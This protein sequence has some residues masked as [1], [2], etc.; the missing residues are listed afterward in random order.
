LCRPG[1]V[2]DRS[3]LLGGPRRPAVELGSFVQGSRPVRPTVQPSLQIVLA[4][5]YADGHECHAGEEDQE[6]LA[7]RD[8]VA[9]DRQAIIVATHKPNPPYASG[10]DQRRPG[11]GGVVSMTVVVPSSWTRWRYTHP[12]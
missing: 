6:P 12:S 2:L 7:E 3:E 8:V 9:R 1:E 5:E 4:Q 10:V 11:P